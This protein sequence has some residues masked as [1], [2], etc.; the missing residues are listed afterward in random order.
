MEQ[1]PNMDQTKHRQRR[2]NLL[3]GWSIGILT[4]ILYVAAFYFR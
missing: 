3:V 2:K 1:D 4:I